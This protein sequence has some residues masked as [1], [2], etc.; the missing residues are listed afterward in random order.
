MTI[1]QDHVVL[2][3]GTLYGVAFDAVAGIPNNA[4]FEVA[5]NT[6]GRISGGAEL[7]YKPTDYEVIDDTNATI[8]RFITK[9]EVTLKSGILTWAME[10]LAKLSPAT[11]TDDT[12]N[13]VK[14]IALGGAKTLTAY[15]IRFVHTED[16]GS[17]LRVTMVATAGSGFK[18][19][20]DPKK[21][22]VIDAEFKAISQATGILVEI[23]EEY[24][25]G[26]VTPPTVSSVVPADAAANILT[27]AYVEWTC[28]ENMKLEDIT[29][30]RVKLQKDSDGT[31]VEGT[32]SRPTPTTVRFTPTAALTA[33]AK[34]R[35]LFLE[36]AR[37][38]AGNAMVA[39]YASTFTCA[40]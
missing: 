22:T 31:F 32:V 34:Y 15:A 26:D 38:T 16:D 9:E 5:A 8:K 28:S 12:V 6:F 18:F 4:T 1:D 27:S 36:G 3:S 25:A 10:N 30:A 37:D 33:G 13:R 11:L 39:P 19:K 24:A 17:K 7:T 14:T 35:P 21:E 20:L 40:A 2:G 23:S 29:S